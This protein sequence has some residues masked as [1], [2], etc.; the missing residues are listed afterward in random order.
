MTRAE[1][2]ALTAR[3]RGKAERRSAWSAARRARLDQ[4]SSFKSA[5]PPRVRASVV[6][7]EDAEARAEVLRVLVGA[8]GPAERHAVIAASR[9]DRHRASRVRGA[10]RALLRSGLVDEVARTG[11]QP[12]RYA[13]AAAP[14]TSG[15]ERA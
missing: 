2:A 10:L 8:G 13:L 7:E 12:G 5:Q 1:L 4:H 14:D 9:L 11:S 15:G 3:E 6:V